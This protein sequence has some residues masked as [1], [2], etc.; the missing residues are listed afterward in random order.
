[1]EQPTPTVT[2]EDIERIV[3]RDFP[4]NS[5]SSVM[6]MLEEYTGKGDPKERY[7]VWAGAL[8][9]A[10]GHLGKLR[11]EIQ[12]AKFDY[13]DVLA[14]AEYPNYLRAGSRVDSLPEDEKDQIIVGDWDQYQEW[15]HRGIR[16]EEPRIVSR[17]RPVPLSSAPEPVPIQA[18][19]LGGCG[20]LGAFFLL[21]LLSLM[22]GGRFFFDF[23]G[24]FFLFI[25]G[26]VMGLIGLA[27]YNKGR[28]DAGGR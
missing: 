7:R 28:R 20:C 26:G 9:L 6:D 1:M 17:E 12:S 15:F 3:R 18:F 19:M 10:E 13:R 24:L 22:V 14:A 8:K 11:M 16:T 25:C 23:F 27:I 21:G 2:Y 4:S 5:F